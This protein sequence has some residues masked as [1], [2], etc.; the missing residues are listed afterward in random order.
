M[1]VFFIGV[2]GTAMG[3]AAVLLKKMGHDVAGS[4][5][6]VYPPMSD[7]LESAGIDLFEGF[8]EH[9]ILEEAAG[10]ADL[11]RVGQLGAA[12]LAHPVED[13]AC[14]GLGHAGLGL[15]ALQEESQVA[16]NAVDNVDELVSDVQHGRW[17]AVMATIGTLKLSG[18]LLANL[19]EQLVLELIELRE[20][21]TARQV[22][23]SAA[24]MVRLREL[25]RPHAEPVH[26]PGGRR[27]E[28]AG[29]G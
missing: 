26:M 25:G 22:L 11:I 14:R 6:G 16:L 2:C 29:A 4:D 9:R 13:L 23:R 7:V 18:S 10:V 5:A 8:A 19:Y 20:L 3:N 28:G 24:P 21:E 1:R 17:D 15:A 12:D 27:E